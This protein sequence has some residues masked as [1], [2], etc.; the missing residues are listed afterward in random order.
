[1]AL[2]LSDTVVQ[3]ALTVN[4]RHGV[5]VRA[6]CHTPL[7]S[8][9]DPAGVAGLGSCPSLLL[10]VSFSELCSDKEDDPPQQRT[11]LSRGHTH[12][13][14]A[15]ELETVLSSDLKIF[16]L[17]LLCMCVCECAHMHAMAHAKFN[18][19]ILI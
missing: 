2:L 3:L 7:V 10:C 16:K 14:C 15:P 17:H 5:V 12:R 11:T 4:P 18:K 19:D 8:R 1:M 13:S 6:I 9:V